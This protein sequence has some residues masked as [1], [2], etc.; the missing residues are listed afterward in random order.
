[1]KLFLDIRTFY[2]ESLLTISG[3]ATSSGLD[4]VFCAQAEIN[5]KRHEMSRFLLPDLAG[6][7]DASFG[8]EKPLSLASLRRQTT[9][10]PPT[11]IRL[12]LAMVR[13]QFRS[14]EDVSNC[15]R[16]LETTRSTTQAEGASSPSLHST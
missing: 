9:S 7:F 15:L 3:G 10:I 13:R 6:A 16:S 11:F 4:M 12:K 1:M 8:A 2:V 14:I 5:V